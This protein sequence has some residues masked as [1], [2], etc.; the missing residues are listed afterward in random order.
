MKDKTNRITAAIIIAIVGVMTGVFIIGNAG[1]PSTA[2]VD[3][4]KLAGLLETT[5][6]W[7]PETTRL[8]DRVSALGL[9]AVG[10]ESYH[11]HALLKVVADGKDVPVPD[12]IGT[13]TGGMASLHTHDADG[14]IHVEAG[15]TYPFTLGQF[16]NVWGVKFTKDQL[17]GFKNTADK[18]VQVYVNGM[19]VE[20]PF[21]YQLK[22]KD[23]IV[24]GYGK[25]GEIPHIN[26]AEFP[27][28]L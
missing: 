4:S 9:P 13:Y 10:N 26:E 14:L 2:P 20:D 6:P 27:K 24:I 5:P 11:Q 7:Q 8:S 23:K 15:E 1:T 3:P 16:M 12:K 21:T 22:Q 17:G 19:I 28:D 18:T 25:N